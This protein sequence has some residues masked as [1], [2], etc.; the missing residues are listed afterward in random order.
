MRRQQWLT[1]CC[2]TG[3]D[4]GRDYVDGAPSLWPG[5]ACPR[6]HGRWVAESIRAELPIELDF[7]AE[8]K[9]KG[10]PG[11]SLLREVEPVLTTLSDDLTAVAEALDSALQ[12]ADE[13]L[14]AVRTKWEARE[15][16]VQDTF[17]KVLRDL[18]AT[19]I[20]AKDF[21][22]IRTSIEE[23]VP[24]RDGLPLLESQLAEA[25]TSRRQLIADWE[26]AKTADFREFDR[27]AARVSRQL[28]GRVRVRVTYAGDREPL[29]ELLRSEVGG[30]LAETIEILRDTPQISVA[31]F[32][33]AWRNGASELVKE[34]GIPQSQADRL[35]T[36]GR[37]SILK[38]EE[39]ELP[40]TTQIELNLSPDATSPNWQR[41]DD[42]STG[43]KATAVLLLLLLESEAPL[44]V[45]Q[46]EDDLD[47]R[48]IT[49][50]IV[51]TMREEKRRRQFIFATHN[52]NIPVLGDAE[53]I[54]GLQATGEAG[55]GRGSVRTARVGSIDNKDVRD[56]TEELLEGGRTAFEMRR[57]KYGF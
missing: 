4:H 53:L 13:G 24:V 50:S 29:L 38:S 39:L 35:A 30:R 3:G 8:S 31:S 9:I 17:D 52:A 51:P 12:R 43:Q 32:A 45:D 22:E 7:V 36:A 54:V 48:F 41:L 14:E 19:K 20:D 33:S 2:R 15:K 56:L 34:F 23:L 40:H 16:V 37:E 27:A 18:Q 47:N 49:E 21:I 1:R 28:A 57:M 55:T 11:A 42:L 6:Q 46:P 10:L 5:C 44:V 25:E 26:D